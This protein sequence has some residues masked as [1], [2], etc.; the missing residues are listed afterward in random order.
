MCNPQVL[1]L[2]LKRPDFFQDKMQQRGERKPCQILLRNLRRWLGT[3][4]IGNLLGLRGEM[5]SQGLGLF[6]VLIQ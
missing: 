1:V 5:L 3:Q 2:S 6:R 4:E